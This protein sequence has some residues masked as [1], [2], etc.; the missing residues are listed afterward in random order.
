[1]NSFLFNLIRQK[2]R[3][4]EQPIDILYMFVIIRKH[5]I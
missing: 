3:G 1:M 4:D 2:E 5:I